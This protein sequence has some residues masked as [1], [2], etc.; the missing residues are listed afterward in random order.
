MFVLKC[1]AT[2]QPRC[3]MLSNY[4]QRLEVEGRDDHNKRRFPLKLVNF[5]KLVVYLG[6]YW[7]VFVGCW[8][9]GDTF[10][11]IG[12]WTQ[13]ERWEK[14]QR[15]MYRSIWGKCYRFEKDTKTVLE[16]TYFRMA[17]GCVMRDVKLCMQKVLCWPWWI[18]SCEFKHVLH[19]PKRACP[20]A[21]RVTWRGW[22]VL[23]ANSSHPFFWWLTKHM[24]TIWLGW[25]QA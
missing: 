2:W 12:W 16:A 23:K 13:E 10:W 7:L 11:R 19:H 8:W 5:E 9:I 17:M 21:S 14:L 22:V 4:L 15:V 6:R 24:L 20:K 3:H 25:Y 1:A 18:A